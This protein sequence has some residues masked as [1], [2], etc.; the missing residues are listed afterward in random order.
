M[1]I[2]ALTC[3]CSNSDTLARQAMKK[4]G[5]PEWLYRRVYKGKN[6]CNNLL[7]RLL[8]ETQ[9]D[10][11]ESVLREILAMISHT[12]KFVILL[13]ID[14]DDCQYADVSNGKMKNRIDAEAIVRD[15]R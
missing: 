13:G 14:G 15:Y 5:D 11:V 4:G 1:S 8:E 10:H 2:Y 7:K 3:T 6:D 12:S 9:S